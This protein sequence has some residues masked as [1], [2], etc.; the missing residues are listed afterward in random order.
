MSNVLYRAGYTSIT[1]AVPAVIAQPAYSY[2]IDQ[3][4]QVTTPSF[5]QVPAGWGYKSV[6]DSQ[7]HQSMVLTYLGALTGPGITGEAT[8]S[9]P[10]STTSTT[11]KSVR[12]DVPAVP[13][14]PGSPAIVINNPPLGWTSDA[15]SIALMRAGLATFSVRGKV[16]GAAVGLSATM[17][18]PVGYSHIPNG[19]LFT[20]GKVYNLA[21]GTF[22]G[23]FVESDVFSIILKNGQ[24]TYK[25]GSTTLATEAFGLGAVQPVALS[26]VMFGPG[27]YVSTPAITEILGG[28]GAPSMAPLTC[29][30][31][32]GTTK[33]IG[34]CTMAPLQCISPVQ[35]GGHVTMRG[36]DCMGADHSYGG[37]VDYMRALTAQ[38]YGA[39]LVPIV[40][41]NGGDQTLQP[42]I[43]AGHGLTGQIGNG[44]P[45]MVALTG[46]GSDHNYAAG[47]VSFQPL[48]VTGY[49]EP[50]LEGFMPMV[51]GVETPLV[52]GMVTVGVMVSGII[53]G[54]TQI[55]SRA[56]AALMRSGI[57]VGTQMA[58]QATM[59]AIMRSIISVGGTLVLPGQNGDTWV[60]NLESNGTSSYTNYEFNSFAKI[61][62]Q[63]FGANASGLFLLE[64]DTDAGTGIEAAISY[65]KRD[66]GTSMM[67][68][69]SEIFVGASSDCKLLLKV[70]ADGREYF[71]KSNN[72][73]EH[74]M[75]QRFKLAKG[76]KSNFIT[77][78]FF[79]ING[80]DF[81]LESVEFELLTLSRR[82]H[83]N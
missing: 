56:L 75:Q 76:V 21:T 65:G 2:F 79:N 16:S 70:V 73:S 80:G 74:L 5:N 67:K 44:T 14:N 58:L 41:A 48:V 8:V 6:T 36:L 31:G 1:P 47:A 32:V 11:V 24:V 40:L 7:G 59:T 81:D 27:D 72:W 60:Y 3:V 9:P 35:Q 19:L 52:G 25:Q 13:G 55:P 45:T 46:G 39:G 82:L 43:C 77:F 68:T 20:G 17:N 54:T 29:F 49:T 51:F 30:G 50:A 33:S 15:H 64:G 26:A 69:V 38:G 34:I 23:T 37:G 22:Y 12:V 57:G 83:G 28:N 53:V 63:Y 66:F 61:G 71:Y 62:E 4:V 10:T 42:M 78:E 18:P